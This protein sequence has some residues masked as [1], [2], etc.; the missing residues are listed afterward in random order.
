MRDGAV[1]DAR[2]GGDGAVGQPSE[3]NSRHGAYDRGEQ[4]VAGE[5]I[6]GTRTGHDCDTAYRTVTSDNLDIWQVPC[7]RAR[8]PSSCARLKKRSTRGD[9]MKIDAFAHIQPP[10]Y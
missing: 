10:V 7:Q 5:P 1:A 2:F 6:G 3:A 4:C 9:A 8:S